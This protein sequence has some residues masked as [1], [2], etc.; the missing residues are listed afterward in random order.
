MFVS[1]KRIK[2]HI[3][4]DLDRSTS[5]F[6]RR[7][8]SKGDITRSCCISFDES[9]QEKHFKTYPRSLSQSNQELV[10]SSQAM[11]AIVPFAGHIAPSGASLCTL[12]T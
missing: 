11:D 6:D 2:L 5:N 12:C 9:G 3:N 4:G 1:S 10:I 7:L 8:R